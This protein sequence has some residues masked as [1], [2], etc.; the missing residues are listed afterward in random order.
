MAK[1]ERVEHR[2]VEVPAR[3]HRL[4]GALL[5]GGCR[6]C[7]DGDSLDASHHVRHALAGPLEDARLG[8][9]VSHNLHELGQD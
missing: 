6:E 8:P 2:R 3:T 5:G 4:A 1:R 7:H 9:G